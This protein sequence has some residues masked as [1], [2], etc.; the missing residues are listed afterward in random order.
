[1]NSHYEKGLQETGLVPPVILNLF[2]WPCILAPSAPKDGPLSLSAASQ[3]LNADNRNRA[4]ASLKWASA[5]APCHLVTKQQ[6]GRAM[7]KTFMAPT[8]NSEKTPG[9]DW[10]VG[11]WE[12]GNLLPFYLLP[13]L[14]HWSILFQTQTHSAPSETVFPSISSPF[15]FSL[16]LLALTGLQ[17]FPSTCHIWL[18]RHFCM[19]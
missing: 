10:I 5:L 8:K 11:D 3:K 18:P 19:D 13:K 9:E 15:P 14:K 1:M 17:I 7:L 6:A 12:K 16:I 2:C 4:G